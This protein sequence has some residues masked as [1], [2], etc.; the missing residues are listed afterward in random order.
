[1]SQAQYSIQ[2][3]NAEKTI[4]LL[5]YTGRIKAE[6]YLGAFQ[7]CG[8]RIEEVE[9]DVDLIFDMSDVTHIDVPGMLQSLPQFNKAAVKNH[10]LSIVIGMS[11]AARVL[12]N[13]AAN[14]APKLI[15]NVRQAR[16]LA[17][18]LQIIAK[19]RGQEQPM[20]RGVTQRLG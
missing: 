1:M 6:P 8:Q 5:H 20:G 14:L 3:H 16:S 11:P 9:H 2:W 4:L 17:E 19:H 18:A 13:A 7:E 12:V 15:G 10:G